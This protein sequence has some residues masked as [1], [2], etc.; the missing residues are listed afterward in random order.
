MSTTNTE[1]CNWKA[2]HGKDILHSPAILGTACRINL[3]ELK[4]SPKCKT[5]AV[6]Y[7]SIVTLKTHNWRNYTGILSMGIKCRA[8]MNQMAKWM[9]GQECCTKFT[10]WYP[11][12]RIPCHWIPESQLISKVLLEFFFVSLWIVSLDIKNFI[13]FH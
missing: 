5:V 12:N 4:S 9:V 10:I 7:L 3:I 13:L 1:K 2:Q 6:N 11:I 8:S